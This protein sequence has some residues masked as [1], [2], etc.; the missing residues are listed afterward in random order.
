MR[1]L[2]A[3]FASVIILAACGTHHD[4]SP[5][6]YGNPFTKP[7]TGQAQCDKDFMD[8]ADYADMK[9][10]PVSDTDKGTLRVRY[11]KE[12]MLKKGYCLPGTDCDEKTIKS[13][14]PKA[15]P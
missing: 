6:V 1:R 8:C 9:I 11:I 4:G 5:V 10:M 7:K 13:L 12:C 3:I 14:E 15:R 2:I